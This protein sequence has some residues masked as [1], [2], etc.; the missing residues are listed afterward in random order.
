M[1]VDDEYFNID[2]IKCILETYFKIKHIDEKCETAMNGL[3]A[4]QKI[5]KNIDDN[6]GNKCDFE[7][8]FIDNNMPIMDGCEAS[9]KIRHYF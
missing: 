6:D 4:Y 1:I 5:I 9:L 2:A 8:I 3:N 7:L